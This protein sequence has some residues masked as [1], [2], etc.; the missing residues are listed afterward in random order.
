MIGRASELNDGPKAAVG[1]NE[2]VRMVNQFVVAGD[3]NL[4]YNIASAPLVS[5]LWLPFFVVGLVALL[6]KIRKPVSVLLGGLLVLATIPVIFAGE[7]PHGLRIMGVFAVLPLIIGTGF[8]DATRLLWRLPLLKQLSA[9]KQF[10]FSLALLVLLI[11]VQ[12][13]QSATGY[14]LYWSTAAPQQTN[15]IFNRQLP[16]NEWYF[17][18]DRRDLAAWIRSQSAPLLLPREELAQQTTHGW[19]AADFPEVSTLSEPI[20]LPVGTTLVIPWSLEAGDLERTTRHFALLQ[21]GHIQ[22]LPPLS[23]ASQQKLLL[24]IDS[25]TAIT[26][27]GTLDLMAKIRLLPA[28]F[29][30]EFEPALSPVPPQQ[31]LAHFQPG[32]TIHAVRGPLVISDSVGELT[33]TLEWKPLQPVNHFYS[34]FLQ[35]QT[36]SGE[37]IAGDD[38]FMGRWL[39]ATPYWQPNQ[40]M[41]D[42]HHLPLTTP[43][44]PGAYKLM[45]GLYLSVNEWIPTVNDEGVVQGNVAQLAWVKRPMPPTPPL[46][47]AAKAFSAVLDNAIVLRHASVNQVD[48]THFELSLEWM[49]RVD[50]P[51][52]DATIFLHVVD[53]AGNMVAQQDK[54]PFEGQYPTF[55]W[56]K[57]ERVVTKHQ[58]ELSQPAETMHLFV[59]MYT[60]PDLQRLPV[61]QNGA[62]IA[63]SRI[64]L[65]TLGGMDKGRWRAA[66]QGYPMIE[67]TSTRQ[68]VAL[69]R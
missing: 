13:Y 60:F 27:S 49:S 30:L 63:D 11:G 15:F 14:F 23:P 32:M 4:Q 10:V 61:S 42:I 38:V 16:S 43:L 7:I 39:L 62:V 20:T 55:I 41:A 17:R 47:S 29:K 67:S 28:D 51:D 52:F 31:A 3:V 21:R 2:I 58:F 8:A 1:W 53:S 5:T 48:A 66:K 44:A 24:D 65:G 34:S 37:R 54:R 68:R 69:T 45:A 50:R 9:Q 46:P 35:L 40:I 26:R 64:D 6:V 19:L 25:T 57:E 33:Y 36:Q 18:P 22:L 12:S 59:G 56:D